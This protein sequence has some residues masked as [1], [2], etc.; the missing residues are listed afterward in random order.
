MAGERPRV[1]I[2]Q[3]VAASALERLRQAADVSFNPNALHIPS[4]NELI[5][6]VRDAH[7]LYC[8]L[9][10]CVDADVIAACDQAGIAMA[11]T[12]ERHFKH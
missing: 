10:D 5:T 2:T 6:A 11:F 7:V 3:P 1:Y 9:Q 4:K 8:L 12:G